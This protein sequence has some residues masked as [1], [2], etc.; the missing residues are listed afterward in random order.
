MLALNVKMGVVVFC[1]SVVKTLNTRNII[2]KFC[3]LKVFFC[4]P[5][6]GPR[7]LIANFHDFLDCDLTTI[8][9]VSCDRDL[10]TIV[11]VF[12]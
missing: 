8:V 11:H 2:I 7:D 4:R 1:R 6:K 3:A 10:T 12:F 5:S 9:H